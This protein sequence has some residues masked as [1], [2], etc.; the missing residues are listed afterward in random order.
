MSVNLILNVNNKIKI[1]K[2]KQIKPISLILEWHKYGWHI[3]D[4]PIFYLGMLCL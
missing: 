2:F 4:W 1:N 3:L